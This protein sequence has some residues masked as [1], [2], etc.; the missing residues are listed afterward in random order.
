M[1]KTE[2]RENQIIFFAGQAA[3]REMITRIVKNSRMSAQ[4]GDPFGVIKI[5]YR[6]SE[7][8]D[9]NKCRPSWS[10]AFGLSLQPRINEPLTK[11][12]LHA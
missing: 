9:A 5:S 12:L 1:P 2:A 4:M 10:V 6:D 8:V 11:Q 7:A 3:D